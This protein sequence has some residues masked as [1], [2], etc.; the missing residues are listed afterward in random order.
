MNNKF[1]R[2]I[3]VILI[4]TIFFSTGI[5]LKVH[6][7]MELENENI[8][9]E[10]VEELLNDE[11]ILDENKETEEV[12]VKKLTLADAPEGY[13]DDVLFIGDSRSVGL[14]T[15]APK[16]GATYFV[17]EGLNVYKLDEQL[18]NVDNIGK[19]TLK[20]LLK[21][22]KFGKIYIMLGINELGYDFDTNCIKYKQLISLIKELQP[23]SIIVIHGNLR[24]TK[25]KS[26]SD[27]LFNNTNINKFNEAISKF[28]DNINTIYIDV[29]PM[30]DDGQGNLNSEYSGDNVHLY[31]NYYADWSKWLD[32]NAVVREAS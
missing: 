4:A 27:K 17:S 15:Y 5:F 2:G 10:D 9:A 25:E 20:D 13:Y 3:S 11:E 6:S 7:K 12:D 30:F 32:A 14:K 18:L 29:N 16:E 31:G 23:E 26:D 28:A 19:T 21:N 22:N 24:V 1:L 8:P